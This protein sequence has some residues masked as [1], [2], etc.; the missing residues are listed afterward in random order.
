MWVIESRT[1]PALHLA[2]SWIF[3]SHESILAVDIGG[4]N[5]R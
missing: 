4:T 3:E 1:M 2:P 5:I